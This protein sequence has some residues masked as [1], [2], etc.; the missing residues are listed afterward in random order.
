MGGGL[1]GFTEQ[2]INNL[3]L[4]PTLAFGLPALAVTVRR[5]HDV[6]RNGWW[7]LIPLTIIGLVPYFYW[8]C[9]PGD[10]HEND[11]G[12]PP[13]TVVSVRHVGADTASPITAHGAP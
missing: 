13:S 9:K 11:Y 6:N 8:L 7:V 1:L 4:L 12:A 5:L 2:G 10:S 3:S